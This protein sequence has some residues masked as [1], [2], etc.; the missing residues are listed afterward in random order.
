[1]TPQPKNHK[2]LKSIIAL[3]FRNNTLERSVSLC[4]FLYPHMWICLF[5]VFIY[6]SLCSCLKL[7]MSIVPL[8]VSKLGAMWG[9]VMEHKPFQN[10][11]AEQ[12]CQ[13][14]CYSWRNPHS[15]SI[16]LAQCQSIQISSV[17]NNPLRLTLILGDLQVSP[18]GVATVGHKCTN[19]YLKNSCVYLVRAG[20]SNI[21]AI[22]LNVA[23]GSSFY[24]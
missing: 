6:C 3:N 7:S 15:P 9:N 10:L 16:F 5:I 14:W 2:H 12:S 1:M 17:D 20:V 18:I 23:P 8:P 11:N 24:G 13:L 19:L 21:R 22:G 4:C